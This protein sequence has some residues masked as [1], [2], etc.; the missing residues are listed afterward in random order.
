MRK[1]KAVLVACLLFSSTSLWGQT[2]DRPDEPFKLGTFELR[3][4]RFLGLVLRDAY[5]VDLE[6]ANQDYQRSPLQVK[7][8]M[9]EDMKE[10]AGR[11]DLDL[12]E[13]IYGI[14]NQLLNEDRLSGA[15][16]P[17]YIYDLGDLKT[18]APILYPNKIFAAAGNYLQHLGEM[19]TDTPQKG[20][21]AYVFQKPSTT[22]VIGNGDFIMMPKGREKMD[23]ECELATVIG[24]PA[25][26]ITLEQAPN[27]I[28][29]YTIMVDVSDR[30]GR[31]ETQFGTDWLIGKGHDTYAPM[32]PFI[33]PKEFIDDPH[34][35]NLH[36]TVNGEVMQDSKGKYPSTVMFTANELVAHSASILTLEPGDVIT[37]GSPAGV[38]AGRNPQV[39]LKRGDVVV[40]TIEKIGSLTNTVK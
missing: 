1:N 40:A 21:M 38:G 15:T 32:G 28:F 27:H 37:A 22:S 39:F 26:D 24:R 17:A 13:R 19:G 14:V 5:V 31:P 16:R 4:E 36:L 3:G 35:L 9:A 6:R 25:K 7:L 20:E 2:T 11:Y 33:V 18:L 34:D 29:G 30:G 10:L 12:R 8:P 23:W